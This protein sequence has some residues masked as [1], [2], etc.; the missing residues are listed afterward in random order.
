MKFREAIDGHKHK[1]R[2]EPARGTTIEVSI[3]LSGER[4]DTPDEARESVAS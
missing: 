3:P 1:I 2:S 4:F